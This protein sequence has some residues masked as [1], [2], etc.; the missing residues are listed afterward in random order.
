MRTFVEESHVVDGLTALES[1]IRISSVLAEAT[2]G[3]PFGS[4][5]G[6][7][8][9][10]TLSL[11]EDLGFQTFRD[12]EGY[13]GYA[14]IGQGEELFGI[15]CHLDV[16]PAGS[17]ENWQTD[18]FV[19]TVQNDILYGRGV[20]DDKGPTI[21]SLYAVKALIDA[22][23]TFNCRLRFIF[24]TDEE[25][26]WRCL[27]R[28]NQKEEQTTR[29]FAPDA[30]FPL[31][32]AEKGLLQAHLIGKN[33][34]ALA[35][36]LPG[37]LNVVPEKAIYQGKYVEDIA[38]ALANLD[39]PF[40]K[41]GDQI[42]VLG[43]SIHAQHAPA[44]VNALSRLMMSFSQVVEIPAFNFLGKLVG[45]DATGSSIFG[46]VSDEVSGEL[47]FNVANLSV[48]EDQ[49]K[50]GVD[51]RIPV[52]VDK[53]AL[54]TK[55][56]TV[57]A[58][59]HLS[60]EEY[61]YLAPLYVPKDSQLVQELLATYREFTGDQTPPEVSGGATFARTMPQCVAFGAVLPTT[62]SLA[63]QPNEAWPIAEFRLAMEIYAEAIYRL[64][65][66]K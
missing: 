46:K 54:V 9:D 50:I 29:G 55:L 66:K 58:E 20:Q 3:C 8:L 42:T 2:A 43:K 23:V 24:G 47:T 11:C 32:Y 25:N 39:F 64:C 52:T 56:T 14:E 41:E 17:L 36:E 13:Y 60:Y 35:F 40:E 27:E 16:V 5:I 7:A 4:E 31:I 15:L 45:E 6:K 49:I 37:A 59:Y 61:D 53:D 63:H 62:E 48:T 21:A 33:D 30:A 1:I 51:L 19:L 22:G 57:L 65:G 44:G 28:Y 26:L 12:P 18:P 10:Q 34:S 38:S